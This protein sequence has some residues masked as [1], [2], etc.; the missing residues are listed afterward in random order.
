MV[1]SAPPRLIRIGSVGDSICLRQR[2]FRLSRSPDRW[3]IDAFDREIVAG[4]AIANAGISGSEV[5]DM[6]LEA[7]EK[8]FQETHPPA[9]EYLSDNGSAYTARKTRLFAQS[10]NLTPSFTPVGHLTDERMSETFVKTLKQGY[11]R[12]EAL[13]DAERAL[14]LFDGWIENYNEIHHNLPLKW[15]SLGSSSG[16]NQPSR[17]S[18]ETGC[19]Q[20][21]K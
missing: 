8:C 13:P 3:C 6:I 16:L 15:S 18:V 1:S 5:R 10:L 19:A 7:V 20:V 17:V 14:R 4:T 12:I 21:A 9:I 11:I 2:A